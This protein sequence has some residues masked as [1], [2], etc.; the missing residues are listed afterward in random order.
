MTEFGRTLMK[1]RV[2]HQLWEWKDLIAAVNHQTDYTLTPGALS[3]YLYETRRP[4]NPQK[5]LTALATAMRLD[6]AERN[7]MASAFA[8]SQRGPTEE[9][10]RRASELEKIGEGKENGGP[11]DTEE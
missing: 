8:Y 6:D 4:R 1:L 9:H 10:R 3:N 2:N 11:E 5:L 7:E